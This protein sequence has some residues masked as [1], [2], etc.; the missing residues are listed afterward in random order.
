M[1]QRLSKKKFF[2]K[3]SYHAENKQFNIDSFLSSYIDLFIVY[4]RSSTT[5][6]R[7]Y[8]L[9]L[10]KCEKNQTNIERMV[11]TIPELEYHQYH[12]FL[13]ESNWDYAAVNKRTAS[14]V[15]AF[16]GCLKAKSGKPTG[17]IID[18]SSHLKKG[19]SSVGVARQYAGVAGKVENCQTGVYAALCNEST[20]CITDAQ[21]FLPQSWIDS[22]E[23]CDKAGIPQKDRVFQTK[24]Q[25]ALKMVKNAVRQ[26][27]KFDWIGGDGLYGHN[28]ELTH[29]LDTEKLFYVLDIH[30]DEKIYLEEPVIAVPERKSTKGKTP[31]LKKGDKPQIRVD[32]YQ[33]SLTE[34]QWEKVFVRN[35]AK[36]PKYVFAHTVAVWHWDGK[37]DAARPRTLVITKTCGPN[38]QIKYSFSNGTVTEYTKKEY[39]YFQCNRYWVERGF[40]DAKNE[41]GLSGYQVRKWNAWQHHQSLVMMAMLYMAQVKNENKPEYPLMSMRDARIMI[42]AS[43][44]SD[45]QTQDILRNQ[46][47]KR[48][49]KRQSDIDRHTMSD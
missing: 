45:K 12:H 14:G 41:L 3:I 47:I 7:S 17:F 32:T 49:Q 34:S 37:E 8:L 33:E 5:V 6:A 29:G 16:I 31:I 1:G 36:G 46:M 43:L 27:V 22:P 39:A 35:T 24:P 30:K 44:F 10:L 42:V 11:E 48:H 21:L 2:K 40:D 15:A 13:S 28:T 26:G 19:S 23:R 25:L 18:E 9:G 20:V 38:P 4:R